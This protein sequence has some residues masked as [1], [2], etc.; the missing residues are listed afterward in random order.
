MQQH[1]ESAPPLLQVGQIVDAFEVVAPLRT[2][3]SQQT[4]RRSQPRSRTPSPQPQPNEAQRTIRGGQA[5]L[6]LVRPVNG[7]RGPV[8]WLGLQRN[9]FGDSTGLA[10]RH[11]LGVIKITEPKFEKNLIDELDYLFR[12]DHER[13]VKPYSRRFANV[14]PAHLTRRPLTYSHEGVSYPYLVLVFEPGGSLQDY[15]RSKNG[16]PQKV[17]QPAQA[18]EVTAQVAEVLQVLHAARVVHRDISPSN[19]V[20]HRPLPVITPRRPEVVLI[21]LA[22][23]NSFPMQRLREPWGRWR[24]LPPE[25]QPRRRSEDPE[26]QNSPQT[27]IYMLGLLLYELL[28]GSLH[29]QDAR[30]RR[31]RTYREQLVAER[32]PATTASPELQQL[33]REAIDR[34]LAAREQALPDM[35]VFADRLRR[36]PEAGQPATFRGRVT[37]RLLTAALTWLVGAALVL[38]IV[39]A[40]AA[41]VSVRPDPAATP[42]PQLAQTP[43]P[44][45]P[46]PSPTQ[47]SAPAIPTRV[48]TIVPTITAVRD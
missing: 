23:A 2:R 24:Y 13:L 44:T 16:A 17:L 7:R 5:D 12:V 33:V 28:T 32:N 6:Y 20:F 47:P 29:Y 30:Q 11:R 4:E 38:A 36:L 1:N 46:V 3:S 43:T 26:P 34:D 45:R 35:A 39:A 25:S 14:V 41:S 8:W 42:S 15:L 18:V 48:P 22:A 19:L 9:L 37:P 21:D 31:D 40:T 27:D 10:E